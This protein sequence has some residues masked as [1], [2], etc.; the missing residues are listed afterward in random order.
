MLVT[1]TAMLTNKDSYTD[2]SFIVNTNCEVFC[3]REAF[4]R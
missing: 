3:D 2:L 4:K 1:I